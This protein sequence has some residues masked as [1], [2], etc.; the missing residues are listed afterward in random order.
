MAKSAGESAAATGEAPASALADPSAADDA[1]GAAGA[2]ESAGDLRAAE[3]AEAERFHKVPVDKGGV[4]T[5][6]TSPDSG[7][8]VGRSFELSGKARVFEATV[9]IEV[10]QNG[11]VVKREFTTA[12]IGAPDLGEWKKVLVLEPGAYKIQT[13]E[14]SAK[15]DGSR[16]G[17]DTIWITVADEAP[18]EG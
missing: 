5:A 13:Y 18:P 15:G 16:L 6:I 1:A 11:S 7:S 17:V 4:Y 9:T 3:P 10:S 8:T 2:S 14:E 12:S